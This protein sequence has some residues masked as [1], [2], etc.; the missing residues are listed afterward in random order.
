MV[1]EIFETKAW[2]TDPWTD[3]V[4]AI[5]TCIVITLAAITIVRIAGLRTLAKM[6]GT[7]FLTTVA[8]GAII[9]TIMLDTK[10]SI[11]KGAIVF[12]TIT[13]IQTIISFAR[14]KSKTFHNIINNNPCLV[15]YK[16]EPVE[17]GLKKVRINETELIAKL[18]EQ[19]VTQIDDV[20]A[21][22]METTGDV[23][24]MSRTD[25]APFDLKLLK[26]VDIPDEKLRRQLQ[27]QRA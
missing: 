3:I 21:V 10:Q 25:E 2:L 15:M 23:S 27:P 26:G 17:A 12:A 20:R 16:G 24:V 11:L 5:I 22:V 18:R 7:D 1:E 8:S 4:Q 9:G 19:G 13:L 6:S 14:T